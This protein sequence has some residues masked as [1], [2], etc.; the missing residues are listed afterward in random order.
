MVFQNGPPGAGQPP[1]HGRPKDIADAIKR[2]QDLGVSQFVFDVVPETR[3]IAL[4][5]MERFAQEV[6]PLLL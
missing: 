4:D 6:R 2:Y 1:T 5:T 3:A